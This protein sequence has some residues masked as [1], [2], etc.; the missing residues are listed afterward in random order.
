M[1][2]AKNDLFSIVKEI[3]IQ[4][5]LKVYR[6]ANSELIE[7]YRQIGKLIVEDEQQGKARAD[8]GKS[9]L[10][11][12]SQ[13]LTL[14]FGKGFDERNLRNIRSFFKAFPIWYALRTELSWTHY[15]LLSQIANLKPSAFYL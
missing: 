3:I 11:N 10:K 2:L 14:E 13:Q 15:R 1:E 8:Y 7:S 6:A 12:L 4:S 5:R 9:T